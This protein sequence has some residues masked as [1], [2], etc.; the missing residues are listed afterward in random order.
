MCFGF[1][2]SGLTIEFR[3]VLNLDPPVSASTMLGF[4]SEEVMMGVQIRRTSLLCEGE[5]PL[6]RSG[7]PWREAFLQISGLLAVSDHLSKELLFQ[8][9]SASSEKLGR[10]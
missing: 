9:L 2:E 5:T 10:V 4:T 3:L 7:L 6:S 8:V 1:E